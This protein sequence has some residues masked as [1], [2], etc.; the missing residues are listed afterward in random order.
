V[1]EMRAGASMGIGALPWVGSGQSVVELA[2]G[3]DYI[4]GD[5]VV[6][7][8]QN[9]RSAICKFEVESRDIDVV[10]W[11]SQFAAYM[12][13]NLGPASPLLEAILQFHRARTRA[14]DG[15]CEC[16]DQRPDPHRVHGIR[17]SRPRT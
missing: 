10:K 2:T 12:Q 14:R 11:S 8:M 16:L 4:T 13:Q 1:A 5:E 7:E 15:G 3:R 17:R 9:G 6:L